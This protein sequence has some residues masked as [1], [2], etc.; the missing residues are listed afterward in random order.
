MKTILLTAWLAVLWVVLWR[1]LTA[2]NLLAGLGTALAAQLLF[3]A[4]RTR[5]RQ[6]TVRPLKLLRF[7]GYF[8]WQ[9]L[10]AN[11]VVA[12]EVLTRR[13]NVRSGIVAIPT[14]GCSDLTITVVADAITLT[15]GTITVEVRH[16]PPALYVHVLH[17]Y[18]IERVRRDVLTLQRMVVQAIGSPEAISQLD[19]PSLA[20]DRRLS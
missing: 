2:A 12:R 20:P 18:D 5:P 6:H 17:L 10:A 14:N 19:N 13:D 7:A 4:K 15:P 1:D 16:D 3:P 11:L 9:L 8:A